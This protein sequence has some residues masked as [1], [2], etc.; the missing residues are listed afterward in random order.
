MTVRGTPASVA[1]LATGMAEVVQAHVPDARLGPDRVPEPK[2]IVLAPGRS[3]S[4]GQT[5]APF[6]CAVY[7]MRMAC[8]SAFSGTV[9]GPVL[10]SGSL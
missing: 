5:R 6:P 9:P 10:L 7:R 2:A 3:A 4:E 1:W 8:A